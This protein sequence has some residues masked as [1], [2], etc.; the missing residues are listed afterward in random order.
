MREYVAMGDGLKW[1]TCNL[2]AE[3]PWDPGDRYSWGAT[4]TQADY[5]WSSYPF[6]QAGYG[7][8][9]H[10]TKYTCPD[11]QTTGTLWYTGNY[12]GTFVG[13]GIT[14]LAG[15]DYEDDAARQIWGGNW[16]IPTHEEWETL[17]NTSYF[18]WV[19]T[20]NYKGSGRNGMLV[21]RKADTGPCSGHS[22]FLPVGGY[23]GGVD[24][25]NASFGEYWS[26]SIS[27]KASD[28]AWALQ[29]AEDRLNIHRYGWRYFRKTLRPVTE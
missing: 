3:N 20:T 8:W 6:M 26:S 25:N 23:I 9:K 7:D 18:E 11:G 16:R 2:G 5:S 4:A 10:I 29:F 22:I 28:Y 1:A 19:W 27:E 15:Y 13:D 21:T 17:H 14:T 12:P 24:L